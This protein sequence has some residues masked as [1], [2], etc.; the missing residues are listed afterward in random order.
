MTVGW[1]SGFLCGS[2]ERFSSWVW[3]HHPR[4]RKTAVR[5]RHGRSFMKICF[6]ETMMYSVIKSIID[7]RSSIKNPT[8]RYGSMSFG[9]RQNLN[10]EVSENKEQ[11][12]LRND[13]FPH[14]PTRRTSALPH[15]SRAN[16]TVWV[17]PHFLSWL[18]KPL[19][20]HSTRTSPFLLVRT[21]SFSQIPSSLSITPRA[22]RAS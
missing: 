14:H 15:F 13:L 17:A 2:G 6:L 11:R 7:E 16:S 1:P 12:C 9:C 4:Q 22:S 10:K 21:F 18:S 5:G 19:G 20:G 3:T 8:P